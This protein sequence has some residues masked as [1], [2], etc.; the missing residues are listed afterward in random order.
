MQGVLSV[1]M[2]FN[3]EARHEFAKEAPTDEKSTDEPSTEETSSHPS[4]KS[5]LNGG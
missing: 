4:N 3:K 5:G 1:E 2:D